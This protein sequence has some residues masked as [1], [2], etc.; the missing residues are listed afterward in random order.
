[1]DSM[2]LREDAALV[3]LGGVV[4]SSLEGA[5]ACCKFAGVLV[6]DAKRMHSTL[7]CVSPSTVTMGGL[8]DL[9]PTCAD[10]TSRQG[11]TRAYPA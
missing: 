3:L 10:H 7:C 11:A 2:V 8:H 5:C 1:M 6:L 4:R 9:V